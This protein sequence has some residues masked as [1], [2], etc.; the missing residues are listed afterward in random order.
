MVDAGHAHC[1]SSIFMDWNW[2]LYGL[3]LDNATLL[4]CELLEL[5]MFGFGM[6]GM[7]MVGIGICEGRKIEVGNIGGNLTLECYLDI[8]M[9]TF[10]ECP[11]RLFARTI[12]IWH[13]GLLDYLL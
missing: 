4:E 2:C 1:E 10:E 9:D 11:T 7:A 13:E 5:E 12:Y 8:R 3:I 6:V